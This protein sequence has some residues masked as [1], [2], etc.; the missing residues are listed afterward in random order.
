MEKTIGKMN[1]EDFFNVMIILANMDNK[2]KDVKLKPAARQG[3]FIEICSTDGI[4]SYGQVC[5]DDL[6]YNYSSGRM[7]T[8]DVADEATRR[9]TA[10]MNES[11][12]HIPAMPKETT[13]FID[14]ETDRIMDI[15]RQIIYDAEK[16]EMNDPTGIPPCILASSK[17]KKAKRAANKSSY[18]EKDETGERDTI[19][20]VAPPPAFVPGLTPA[21]SAHEDFSLSLDDEEKETQDGEKDGVAENVIEPVAPAFDLG[22]EDEKKS[23]KTASSMGLSDVIAAATM[24]MD[25]PEDGNS[26]E[27]SDYGVFDL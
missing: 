25:T 2:C 22:D 8:A 13:P 6:Y 5:I 20:K 17:S 23:P 24:G 15:L 14:I 12:S 18:D 3:M 16:A 26:D 19:S 21:N 7:E 9:V 1:E 27:D 4:K 11:I 10:K